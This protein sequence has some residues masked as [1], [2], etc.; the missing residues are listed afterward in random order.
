MIS[1]CLRESVEVESNVLYSQLS[2]LNSMSVNL[3]KGHNILIH[4][5]IYIYHNTFL[6]LYPNNEPRS[7]ILR[8]WMEF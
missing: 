2:N 8:S 3:V 5:S 1:H 6:N 7:I 4:S